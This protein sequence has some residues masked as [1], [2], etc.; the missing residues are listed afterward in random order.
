MGLTSQDILNIASRDYILGNTTV[1]EQIDF[2]TDQIHDPFGSGNT[3]YFKKLSGMVKNQDELDKICV[4]MFSEIENTYP[5]LEF[6]FSEV[7]TH[8]A[9]AFSAAY[10]FLIKN[11][12]KS[13]YTF[14]KEYISSNKNR[15]VLTAD[16]LSQKLPSYPKEQYGKKEFYI[17]ITKLPSII[18]DI[19]DDIAPSVSEFIGYIERSGS[20]QMYLATVKDLLDRG[21]LLDHGAMR[22]IFKAFKKSDGYDEALC[23][24]QMAITDELITPYLEESGLVE[25]RTPA[26]TP[27][28]DGLDDTDDDAE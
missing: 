13:M 15:K 11:A 18:D 8:L 27:I 20:S 12:Q 19:F 7:T 28:D 24:L 23:K 10:K 5:N 16:Y 1:N 2:L 26:V 4:R 17:L 3:N 21:Y 14:L 9:D 22:S 25:Y 6:D